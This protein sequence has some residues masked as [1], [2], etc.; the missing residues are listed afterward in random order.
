MFTFTFRPTEQY[1]LHQSNT[2][3]CVIISVYNY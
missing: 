3:T 1:N 2:N